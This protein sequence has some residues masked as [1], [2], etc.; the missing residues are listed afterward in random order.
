MHRIAEHALDRL[1]PQQSKEI[2][3]LEAGQNAVL[4]FKAESMQAADMWQTGTIDFSGRLLAL[5]SLLGNTGLEWRL[6]VAVSVTAVRSRE[7][8]VNVNDD[9]GLVRTRP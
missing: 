2:C 7:L 1:N 3:P 9:P 8:A 4:L 6:R 5:V